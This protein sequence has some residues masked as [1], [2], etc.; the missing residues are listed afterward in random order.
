MNKPLSILL[1]LFLLLGSNLSGQELKCNIQVNSSKIQGTNRTAFQTLQTALYEFMNNSTWT[2]HVYTQEERIDC[3]IQIN[4][5]DQIGS[6]QYKGT[7]QVQSRRPVYGSSYNTVMLN[8]L[9]NDL[10][11]KYIEFDKLEFNINSFQSNLTSVLAYYA[12]IIIGL[13]YDSFSFKGGSDYFLKAEKI[14]TNAQN[15]QEKGWKP[16][17]GSRKNR[18]WLIENLLNEK[19]SP[20]REVSYR[21]HRQGLDRMADKTVDGRAEIA[22]ALTSIQKVYR[23]KPDPYLFL[24]Q[25]FFDAKSEELV[26]IFSESFLSEKTRVYNILVEVDP[27]RVDTYKKI[28]EQSQD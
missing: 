28:N 17:E 24:L 14:V 3:N 1:V 13:D 27:T 20:M 10:D 19:Y 16:Y 25:V 6:D 21:Y 12:Y 18:Y 8:F 15:A 5:T 9:D 4:I 23:V 7:I 11:F 22:E 26:N 2:D